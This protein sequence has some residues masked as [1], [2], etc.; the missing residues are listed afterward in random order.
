ML[1]NADRHLFAVCAVGKVS[2]LTHR[3]PYLLKHR[4]WGVVLEVMT[5]ESRQKLSISGVLGKNGVS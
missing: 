3:W 4:E 5:D 1:H 2:S